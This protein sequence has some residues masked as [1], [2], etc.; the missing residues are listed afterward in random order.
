[1]LLVYRA[2]NIMLIVSLTQI[3]KIYC[4][5][6]TG[7][8][9]LLVSN[10][11]SFCNK[12]RSPFIY[13]INPVKVYV[14]L[15]YLLIHFI[16]W[17]NFEGKRIYWKLRQIGYFDAIC[18]RS[19]R[20]TDNRNSRWLVWCSEKT[21]V[22][23]RSRSSHPQECSFSWHWH[24]YDARHCRGAG[25]TCSQHMTFSESRRMI[26]IL[27]VLELAAAREFSDSFPPE[28]SAT[29]RSLYHLSALSYDLAG[30]SIRKFPSW[31]K[32]VWSNR[33]CPCR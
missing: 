1:M 25:R 26:L 10:Y 3:D 22:R 31:S 33:K 2:R 24:E 6:Q 4:V 8:K 16:Q 15:K 17:S 32:I 29:S 21:L 5:A 27:R 14:Q 30:C 13:G 12:Y 7:R 28:K 9:F 11:T 23:C 18:H 20:R 19:A